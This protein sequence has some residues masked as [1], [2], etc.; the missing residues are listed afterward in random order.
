MR[1]TS[2][3]NSPGKISKVANLFNGGWA[4]VHNSQTSIGLSMIYFLSQVRIS[5]PVQWSYLK[6]IY[7]NIGYAVAVERIF[8]GGRDTISLRHASLV[9][10]TIWVLMLVKQ[11]LRLARIALQTDDAL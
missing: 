6:L 5:S 3:S 11:H 2:I 1:L 8:S 7:H 9:P 4:D 10:N